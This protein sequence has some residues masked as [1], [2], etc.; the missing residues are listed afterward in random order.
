MIQ[1][2]T[3]TPW[4]PGLPLF[5]GLAVVLLANWIP[6]IP[7]WSTFIHIW[8]VDLTAS[9]FLLITLSYLI[10]HSGS[11]AIPL[12][13]SSRERRWI[14]FPIVIFIA[15]SA[16]SVTWASSPRSAIHHTLVWAEYLIFYLLVR[17]LVDHRDNF[18]RLLQ[19]IAIVLVLFALPA[20]IEYAGT[21]TVSGESTLRGRYAK[22]GEQIITILPLLI[23]AS[24][25]LP[26]RAFHVS[27]AVI[28]ILWLL[29]YCT[30]ARINVL[31]FIFAFVFT[32]L[33]VF[34]IRRFHRYRARLAVCGLALILA[35]VPFLALS[36]SLGDPDIPIANRLADTSGNE[37][38]NGFRL[39]MNSVSV[40]MIRSKPLFGVGADNYGFEFNTFRRQHALIDPADEN[41]A[42]GEFGIVGRAHNELLQVA[43]E[44]GV[45]GIA[46][47]T[48]LLAGL[49]FLAV[50]SVKHA[51]TQSLYPLAAIL[52]LGMFLVSSLVSSYS[53]RLMQNG[54]VFFFVLAVAAKILFR[55]ED[56][57]PAQAV[58][59]HPHRL[60]LAYAFGIL[61]CIG[62]TGYSLVRVASV[63]VTEMANSTRSTEESM[64]L[65]ELAMKLDGENPDVRQNLGMRLLR[66]QRYAEAVP[67]LESSIEIGRAQAA[68]FSYLATAKSLSGDLAGAEA[69]M[70]NAVEL[71]PQS[72]FLLTRYATLLEANGKKGE[73]GPVFHRAK[74]IDARAA[75]SW[76]ALIQ[77]GPKALSEI[78]AKDDSYLQVSELHPESSLFAV[79]TERYIRFPDEQRFSL[80]KVVIDEE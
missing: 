28:C 76:R 22:Y 6:F 75:S 11:I 58:A 62:L 9:V 7:A 18:R 49:A 8:R 38:S 10:W 25:R 57:T 1:I 69:T 47:I 65:Y 37:Y 27:L 72:P 78:A 26:R 60:K 31:L 13:P 68:E 14:V 44:L 12:A 48:W 29:I 64:P 40:E 4:T 24:L 36:W 39:L 80:V 3:K 15:W 34:A 32:F 63:V 2:Q 21:M 45:I 35:P 56:Q 70:K 66:R 46:I 33:P 41:L 59:R 19:T 30:A 74:Q 50:L 52:G 5:I 16:L 54:F 17:H 51:R 42:Y 20:V 61:A 67:Y 23:I 71:Y 55:R 73:S 77:S 53:F 79:V 43:A